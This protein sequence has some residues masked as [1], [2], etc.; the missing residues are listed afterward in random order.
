MIIICL[1]SYR[2]CFGNCVSKTSSSSFT[3]HP[4]PEKD[5]L[6]KVAGQDQL[7]DLL[8]S[9]K[10]QDELGRIVGENILSFDQSMWLRIAT[11]AGN[12]E[13]EEQQKRV[14]DLARACMLIVDAMVKSTE[15]KMGQSG[16][17]LQEVLK[18]CANKKGEWEL[19]LD[20]DAVGRLRS[21]LQKYRK[22][23]KVDEA[24]L[25][26]CFSWMRKASDDRIDGMVTLLQKV[27]QVY[28]ATELSSAK[29]T[30]AGDEVLNSIISSEEEQWAAIIKDQAETG[31]ISETSLMEALQKRMEMT[32]LNLPSGSY[33]QRV[34]AEYLKEFETRAKE[35]FRDL[36]SSK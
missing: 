15:K 17:V 19:P 11:R 14:S 10:S 18:S 20:Q 7:I 27:L 28:A 30:S 13:T 23:G 2:G 35:V 25:A 21:S 32:V 29:A 26:N 12:A 22:E 4:P 3:P 34:Q 31:A 16:E 9:A 36:A 33:A 5:E 6:A 1:L 24:M 8:L